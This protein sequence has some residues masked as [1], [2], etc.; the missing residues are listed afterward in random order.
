MTFEQWWEDTHYAKFVSFPGAMQLAFKEIAKS[1]WDAGHTS[2]YDKGYECGC[3]K[4]G[5]FC[6]CQ[7]D[8]G[9]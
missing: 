9:M 4:P 7:A 1:A 6:S 5:L 2:G 3:S 8:V